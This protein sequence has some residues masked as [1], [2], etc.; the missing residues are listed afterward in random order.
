MQNKL[1]S[2]KIIKIYYNW[3]FIGPKN[4]CHSITFVLKRSVLILW[5]FS[6]FIAVMTVEEHGAVK[7]S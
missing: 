1:E 4:V 7:T 3:P 6:D 2:F 5:Y